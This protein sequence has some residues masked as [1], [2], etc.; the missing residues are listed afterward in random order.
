MN[1]FNQVRR[2]I[3]VDD[4]WCLRNG[5]FSENMWMVS[6]SGRKGVNRRL[7]S[8]DST[9]VGRWGSPPAPTVRIPQGQLWTG[10]W[11]QSRP[12]ACGGSEGF[13][14]CRS[15]P[16]G[17]SER[18]GSVSSG[19]SPPVPSNRSGPMGSAGGG[20]DIW[21]LWSDGLLKVIALTFRL[22]ASTRAL[23]LC[24]MVLHPTISAAMP[25]DR[26][27]SGR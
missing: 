14:I 2:A 22:Y 9:A 4:S 20:V 25:C 6:T 3:L 16:A 12:A 13:V 17:D 8:L 10:T 5:M 7:A 19:R 21:T 11:A 27:L 23:W 1:R 26:G 15:G 24:R 18:Y